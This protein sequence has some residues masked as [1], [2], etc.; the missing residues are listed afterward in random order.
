MDSSDPGG[1]IKSGGENNKDAESDRTEI[2]E[3]K[4][5]K[6]RVL[7]RYEY[8]LTLSPPS[9][10][11]PPTPPSMQGEVDSSD[12]EKMTEK[13]RASTADEM[14]DRSE[15][16]EEK[17][18]RERVLELHEYNLTALPPSPPSPQ[19][20]PGIPGEEDSDDD[21]EMSGSDLTEQTEDEDFLCVV[22]D[23]QKTWVTVEDENQYAV[24]RL[25]E[26]FRMRPLLPP[27]PEDPRTDWSEASSGIKFPKCHCA[28]SG[29]SWTS[30]RQPC[31]VR[32][33][34]KSYWKVQNGGWKHE[35]QVNHTTFG[36]CS[37]AACLK[38]HIL[39]HHYDTLI[40]ACGQKR[41][42]LDSYDYY[43]EAIKHR[44][45]MR[46]PVL[47]ASID[48]R[49]FQYVKEAFSDDAVQG[50]V[51][52]CCATVRASTNSRHSHI[53]YVSCEAYFN[54]IRG[55][56]FE[57]NWNFSAYWDRYGDTQAMR[58][59]PDL[60]PNAWNWKRRLHCSKYKGEQVKVLCC[61]E[62]VKCNANTTHA[63][64]LLC[65]KCSFP[66]CREC[67]F[68]SVKPDRNETGI[69]RALC[70]DNF[71]G[72]ITHL[73]YKWK[74]R[75]IEAAAACPI[76]TAMI[77][78]YVEGDR[79]HLLNEV[80]HQAEFPHAVRGNVYSY[81]MPWEEVFKKLHSICSSKGAEMSQLP[82]PPALLSQLV[83]FNLRIGDVVELNKW[84]PQA[85]LRPHVV[86]KLLCQLVDTNYAGCAIAENTMALKK[87]LK[88]NV[89][90][91]YPEPDDQRNVPEEQ[92]EGF[93]PAAVE[94]A[95]RANRKADPAMRESR[96]RQKHGTPLPAPQQLEH[97]L[98][99]VRPCHLVPQRSSH[100]L[101]DKNVQQVL[102]LG[103]HYNLKVS[104][105]KKHLRGSM[106]F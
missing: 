38:E 70:N 29:C 100:D 23:K 59:H 1:L 76:F 91:L 36:C 42:N 93:I 27:D 32:H 25:S 5:E 18:E 86:L 55:E 9:P 51:C 26:E 94:E 92:R 20:P 17:T 89:E 33:P 7:E 41:V 10:P 22:V 66:L 105:G 43:V 60:K 48:R 30:V 19:S 52:M 81:H 34:T 90:K 40:Q 88:L 2:A 61:P 84:L 53:G 97:A 74:V 85:R 44:E 82:H 4:A 15:T 12:H 37:D 47:G 62:D 35:L 8:L 68:R 28:F 106:E 96:F 56:S 73:I 104:T 54:S 13:G 14:S 49:C 98:E 67:F 95:I 11:S 83:T 64:D 45:S 103:D 6:N 46:L 79:G 16:A 24:E 21:S 102:G 101:V 63:S 77:C 78:Y 71:Y 72:F 75:W 50:L 80:M 31:E 58:N 39:T 57:I 3:E 99:D 69:P 87:K 65:N